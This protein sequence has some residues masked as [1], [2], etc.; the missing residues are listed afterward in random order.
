M[1][2]RISSGI[3]VPSR[4][5]RE[6]FC[7]APVQSGYNAAEVLAELLAGRK[8]KN[9]DQRI[10]PVG[11]VTRPSSDVLAIKVPSVL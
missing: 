1:T 6:V 3:R 11:V 8:P 7:L 5:S 9:Y 10:E 4:H 2:C